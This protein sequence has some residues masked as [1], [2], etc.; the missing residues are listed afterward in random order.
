MRCNVPRGRTAF[1]GIPFG[2]SRVLVV[3]T[4]SL[5]FEREAWSCGSEFGV[6]RGRQRKCVKGE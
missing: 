4:L 6:V 2:S 5:N 3:V 1:S